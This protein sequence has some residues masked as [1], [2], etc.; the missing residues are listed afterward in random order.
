MRI[1]TLFLLAVLIRVVWA[2]FIAEDYWGDAD[3]NR[4]MV[5]QTL[6]SGAYTDYKDRHLVWLPMYRWAA[7][8]VEAVLPP[9]V[10]DVVVPFLFQ[11][12]YMAMVGRW[13][14]KTLSPERQFKALAIL[15]FWPLPLVF[16]GFNMAENAALLGVTGALTSTGPLA[17]LWVVVSVLSRHEATAFLA[18]FAGLLML[19]GHVR[20]SLLLGSG[21]AAGLLLWSLYNA[22]A[23]GDAWFWLRSL[24]FA[25]SAGAGEY[26][27]THGVLP[28]LGEA[29]FAAVLIVPVLFMGLWRF[30]SWRDRT[31]SGLLTLS[32]FLFLG[33]FVLAAL[34]FFH[35]ADPKYLL[36]L[37]F[38][39]S[40]WTIHVAGDRRWVVWIL[41]ALLPGYMLLFHIRSH[42][43]ELERQVGRS[44]STLPPDAVVWSDSPTVLVF[45]DLHASQ[46]VSSDQIAKGADVAGVL[47]DWAVT[48]VVAGDW[49]HSRALSWFPQLEG[50]EVFESGGFRFEPVS[51][52]TPPEVEGRPLHRLRAFAMNASPPIRVWRV[53]A[54]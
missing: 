18:L 34:R 4:F 46:A 40:M 14:M 11:L 19:R 7:I 35:G 20:R 6:E 39:F 33:V 31:E 47:N 36:V 45:A 2:F 44:L 9:V 29:L 30:P 8:A 54:L 51:V 12:A 22:L 13:A 50:T 48:H 49:S 27:A 43:L 3:H 41:I 10:P 5:R 15:W 23:I 53:H 42:T 16:S 28:R 17:F 38:P 26:I 37:A 52:H 24:F 32:A 25:S 1:R 21:L